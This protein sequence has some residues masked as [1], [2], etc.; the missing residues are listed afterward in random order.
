MYVYNDEDNVPM[1]DIPSYK[2]CRDVCQFRSICQAEP[3]PFKLPLDCVNYDYYLDKS[4]D[5]DDYEKMTH[6][7]GYEDE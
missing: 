7:G 2:T 6:K 3:H 5:K 4:M 1:I